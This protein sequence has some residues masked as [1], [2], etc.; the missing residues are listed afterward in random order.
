MIQIFRIAAA[1][2]VS[3]P[4]IF[5]VWRPEARSSF[6]VRTASRYLSP[7]IAIYGTI[8]R[9]SIH[10]TTVGTAL[11]ATD[12][13]KFFGHDNYLTF[14]ASVDRSL[15]SFNTTSQLGTIFPDLRCRKWRFPGVWL[16]HQHRWAHWLCAN[17]YHWQYDLLR[18]LRPRYFQHHAGTGT[19][20]RRR[21]SISRRSRRWM[22]RA[23]HRNSTSTT[24]FRG[25]IRSSA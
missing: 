13:D 8:D 7:P 6:W 10:A 22:R 18:C 4:V 20:R 9:T 11:Q 23:R 15:L 1:P 12:N 21:G 16:D 14:G 24:R 3:T 25:S 19:D 17:L 5:R 2:F